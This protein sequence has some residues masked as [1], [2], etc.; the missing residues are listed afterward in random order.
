[1]RRMLLRPRL[2]KVCAKPIPKERQGNKGYC[3]HSCYEESRKGIAPPLTGPKP[4]KRCGQT[5]QPKGNR[6][7]YCSVECKRGTGI[8]KVC[9]KEFTKNA[10]TTGE[11]C[12]TDCWYEEFDRVGYG[13]ATKFCP[14]CGAEVHGRNICCST[15]C[16]NKW[17]RKSNP[18]RLAGCKECGKSLLDKKAG[19]EFCD[20]RCSML[21]RSKHGG[22]TQPDGTRKPGSCGYIVIKVNG[23]WVLEHRYLMSQHLGK[24]LGR[25]DYVHHKN[26]QR[27]DNRIE[28]LELCSRGTNSHP[29]GQR[30]ADMVPLLLTAHPEEL[31]KHQEEILRLF[32][33]SG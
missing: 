20:C 4:C 5:F 10:N 19:A 11:F 8:C 2:C 22:V 26:G 29:P 6:G 12:S 17:Q 13:T 24:E 32:N 18:K 27:S 25:Y 1:M 3:S 16:K 7:L 28:N 21:Y 33:K 30:M 9:N 31:I 14:N 23:K 15:D